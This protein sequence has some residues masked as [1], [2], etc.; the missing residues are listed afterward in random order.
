MPTLLPEPWHVSRVPGAPSLPRNALDRGASPTTSTEME[1]MRRRV[2]HEQGVAT[3]SIDE[4]GDP[5]LRQVITNEAVRRWGQR[6]GG[7]HH[8]R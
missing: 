1:C 7:R 6:N 3:F 2:W 5:W 4:V 8:G